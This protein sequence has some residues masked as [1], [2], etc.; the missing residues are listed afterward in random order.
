MRYVLIPGAGGRAWY[1]HRVLPLLTARGHDALAVELPSDNDDAGLGDY[2]QSVV[3]AAQL[4]DA[5]EVVVV[6][7]SLGGFTASMVLNR[8]PVAAVVLVNAM[9]PE[10]GESPAEWWGNTGAVQAR[11]EQA[12]RLGY[13][14]DFDPA[15]YLL[16]DVPK[17]VLATAT[18]K[19]EQSRRPFRDPCDFVAWP[20][21]TVVITGTDDRFLPAGFQQRLANERLGVDPVQVAGGH[22]VALSQPSALGQAILEVTDG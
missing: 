16:H 7:A 22:L 1:W 14:V 9:I 12:T 20:S 2:A 3:E 21:R 4:Q 10:P 15:T 6:A 13:A 17:D 5:S 8:L 18:P 19:G 11:T